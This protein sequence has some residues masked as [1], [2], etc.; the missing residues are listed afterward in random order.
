VISREST[1]SNLAW[2]AFRSWCG[3][4]FAIISNTP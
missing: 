2:I 1:L 3:V 4:R